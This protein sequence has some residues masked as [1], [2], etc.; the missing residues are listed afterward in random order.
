MRFQ[1]LVDSLSIVAFFGA[2]TVVALISSEFGYRLG[3]W[4]QMR[5]PE[6]KEGPTSMIVGSLLALMAFLLAITMGI[7]SDRFDTRRNL[8]L[9][10]AN[11]MGT[12]YLRAGCLPEPASSK[13]QNLIREYAPLRIVTSDPADLQTKMARSVEIQNKIWTITA[14]LARATPDSEILSLFIT[15]LNEMIDLHETR[16]AAGQYARVPE[17]ILILLLVCSMLT[18]ATVGYNAGLTLRR[19]PLTAAIL[20][21][22]LGAVITLVVDLDRPQRGFLTVS[23]Q[24]LIDLVQQI[25]QLPPESPSK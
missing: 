2:F 8:V 10:E 6:E 12:T 21:I 23:Q 3:C 11:C 25:G 16:L 18:L 13:I 20:I 4:W 5:T 7:A 14:E 15:S 17:T 22:V 24:P 9:T 1:H 19:S